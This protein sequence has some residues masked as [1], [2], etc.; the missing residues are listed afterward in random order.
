MKFE[1]TVNV[2]NVMTALALLVGFIAAHIQNQEKLKTLNKT[3]S[4]A[5]LPKMSNR[6]NLMFSW[7]CS[8]CIKGLSPEDREKTL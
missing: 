8:N 4:D 2:G 1:W 3:V 6:V 5:E 7:W